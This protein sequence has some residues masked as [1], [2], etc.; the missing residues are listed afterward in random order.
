M[1]WKVRYVLLK[2]YKGFLTSVLQASYWSA[3]MRK[4]HDE[5][6]SGRANGWVVMGAG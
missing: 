6:T 1:R 5:Q 2:T 3:Y 4:A